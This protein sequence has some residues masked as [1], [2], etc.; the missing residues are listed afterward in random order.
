M[1]AALKVLFD[2]T[3][4]EGDLP[5]PLAI[6][7]GGPLRLPNEVVYAN[8]VASIDGIV[9]IHDVPKSSAVISGG[10]DADRFVMGLLRASADAVVIG[11]GTLREH[12]G[13]WTGEASYPAL[14]DAF[15]ELRRREERA[16]VPRLVVLTASGRLEPKEALRG[17]LVLTTASGASGLGTS[18]SETEVVALGD[19]EELD[20][21]AV[22]EHLRGLG[23]RRTLTE[24]GPGVMAELFEAGAIDELFLT[25]APVI[26][27][28]GAPGDRSTLAPN[29][30]LLPDRLLGGTL[31]SARRD[32]SYLFLRYSLAP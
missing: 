29:I 9:A 31:V 8:F 6:R 11:A 18:L 28:G 7:Y 32:E 1:N 4:G 30:E 16:D 3:S 20:V 21:R 23:Y 5:E 10:Y 22:T 12:S 25:V 26:A 27:G 14:A 19:G 17:A 24:G 13:P 2:S 15:E